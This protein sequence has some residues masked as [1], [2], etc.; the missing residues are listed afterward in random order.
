MASLFGPPCRQTS[1]AADDFVTYSPAVATSVERPTGR[2]EVKISWCSNGS[3]R[4]YRCRRTG[5]CNGAHICPHSIPPFLL[6]NGCAHAPHQKVSLLCG[7]GAPCNTQFLGQRESVLKTAS[8]L[9]LP[10]SRDHGRYQR[11]DH[12]TLSVAIDRFNARY[13]M[14][15]KICAKLQATFVIR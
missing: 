4:S 5:P 15:P 2:R 1:S 14:R 7:I 10:F 12:T 8:R 13:A 9:I 6:G 11:R 3:N